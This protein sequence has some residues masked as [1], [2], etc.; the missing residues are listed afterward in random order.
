MNQRSYAIAFHKQAEADFATHLRLRGGGYPDCHSLHYMQMACEKL[1]KSWLASRRRVDPNDLKTHRL[2]KQTFHV[3]IL[4]YCRRGAVSAHS[5]RE[6][7][8]TK[9]NQIAGEVE[10]LSPSVEGP[11][12]DPRP[13]NCE[14][15][16]SSEEGGNW[17]APVD[18][19]FP[20][21]V[22]LCGPP[23]PYNPS[24]AAG[25]EFTKLVQFALRTLKVELEGA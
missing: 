16:W 22:A 20:N 24:K 8:S 15:P 19:A 2:I 21:L 23:L 25:A 3:V 13:E 11:G 17:I 7:M 6:W 14:Y 18:Y 10:R 12:F 4:E 9:L 5:R 1:A